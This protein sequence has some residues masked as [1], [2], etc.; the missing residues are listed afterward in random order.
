[1]TAMLAG[2]G[3]TINLF[4]EPVL[5]ARRGHDESQSSRSRALHPTAA[6]Y[7]TAIPGYGVVTQKLAHKC[8]YSSTTMNAGRYSHERGR[9]AMSF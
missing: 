8:A 3:A 5:I 2:G 1:M 7:G 4:P 9:R 6:E